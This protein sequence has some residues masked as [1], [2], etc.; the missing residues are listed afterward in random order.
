MMKK[1]LTILFALYSYNCF[2]QKAFR[3]IDSETNKPV[4]GI[5]ATIYKNE[6]SFENC[7]CSNENGYYSLRVQKFDST[8]NYQFCLDYPKY[9]SIWNEINLTKH[10]TLFVFLK[11]SNYF[12]EESDSLFSKGCSVYSFGNYYPRQPHSLTDL[13]E[14][15]ASKVIEYLSM[16]VGSE[17]INS[18]K[19]IGGQIIDLDK[20]NKLF[21]LSIRQTAYYLCFSFR[22]LNAGISMYT[23]KIE[24]D[25]NGNILKDIEFP[26][27]IKDSIQ[28]RIFPFSKILQKAIEKGFC[29]NDRSKIDMGYKPETNILIWKFINSV[30]NSDNTFKEEV[31]TFNAHNGDYIET[32]T[33]KG[34]WVE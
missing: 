26:R 34:V 24:L 12:I 15:I 27:I 21:P 14:N 8:A 33:Q 19:L 2:S 6:T 31:I 29:K 17:R 32:I 16:R 22:D 11:K 30:F 10:D 7:G 4:C 1:A 5:Y 13:P 9:E 28:E 23:S 18:F 25:K 3:F 20:F